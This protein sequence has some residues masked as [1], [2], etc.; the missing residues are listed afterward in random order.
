MGIR[1]SAAVVVGL[2]WANVVGV[3]DVGDDF[4]NW[5]DD[6]DMEVVDSY[7]DA[8][9]EDCLFGF[10]Y[11]QSGDYSWSWFEWDQDKIDKL[12]QDFKQ[13]TGLEPKVYL[14]LSSH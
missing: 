5:I 8:D 11:K 12:K 1:Y 6:N 14:S 3:V 10:V 2:P 7:Y 13:A 4:Q 9:R